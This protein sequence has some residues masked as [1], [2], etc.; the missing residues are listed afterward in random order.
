MANVGLSGISGTELLDAAGR[1]SGMAFGLIRGDPGELVYATVEL[2][3]LLQQAAVTGAA[4][5]AAWLRQGIQPGAA[6]EVRAAPLPDGLTVI[7][8]HLAPT[9]RL[10]QL[11]DRLARRY[12]LSDS[13]HH[14]LR[15][16]AHGLAIKDS[17]KVLGISPETVRVRRKRVYRKMGLGGHE[18]LLARL[19]QEALVPHGSDQAA[20]TG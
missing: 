6:Y 4:A 1:V 11:L 14:E 12:K 3:H 15:H 20:R 7:T 2:Q 9:S 16:L 19:C 5:Q 18:A 17:A 10:A 13:E 8:A